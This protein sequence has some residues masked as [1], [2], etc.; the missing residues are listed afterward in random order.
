MKIDE[1]GLKVGS[2]IYRRNAEPVEITEET[3]ASWVIGEHSWDKIK[4]KKAAMRKGNSGEHW[5][6]FFVNKEDA[7]DA[8]FCAENA[9]KISDL[10]RYSRDGKALRE[11]AKLIG[12]EDSLKP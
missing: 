11:T 9:Y 2:I 6:Q 1:H 5:V 12:Y 3:S 4:I 8:R 7:L 10:I